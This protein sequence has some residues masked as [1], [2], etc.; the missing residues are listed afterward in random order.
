[1]E[2]DGQSMDLAWR[3][4][5]A[6]LLTQP[7]E[8]IRHYLRL[9][10]SGALERFHFWA[11]LFL[12][13]GARGGRGELVTRVMTRRAWMKAGRTLLPR[14][15]TLTVYSVFNASG[16]RSDGTGKKYAERRYAEYDIQDTEGPEIPSLVA[17]PPVAVNPDLVVMLT[18]RFDSW[19][20]Q[21]AE[22]IEL[23]TTL[24][25]G[26]SD[27]AFGATNGQWIYL[28]PGLPGFQVAH[29]YAHEVAH[30]ILGHVSRDPLASPLVDGLFRVSERHAIR[31]VEADVTA[32]IVCAH[33]GINV[34]AHTKHYLA[35]WQPETMNVDAIAARVIDAVRTILEF[36]CPPTEV[37]SPLATTNVRSLVGALSEAMSGPAAGDSN[38]PSAVVSRAAAII[39][40]KASVKRRRI[41]AW[42][43]EEA[44]R[45]FHGRFWV[46][47]K[48]EVRVLTQAES[49]LAADE[50]ES[51]RPY[52]LSSVRK[53][54][55]LPAGQLVAEPLAGVVDAFLDDTVVR[56]RWCYRVSFTSID[57]IIRWRVF[58]L[59]SGEC[60]VQRR[61]TQKRRRGAESTLVA[62]VPGW[63][64]TV[65]LSAL[66]S[67]AAMDSF[68][69]IGSSVPIYAHARGPQHNAVETE[70]ADREIAD[71]EFDD[72]IGA[73]Q[74]SLRFQFGDTDWLTGCVHQG[75]HD[76]ITG[77]GTLVL[78]REVRFALAFATSSGS[79]VL[80]VV[81][82][83]TEPRPRGCVDVC[84]S[85]AVHAPARPSDVRRLLDQPVGFGVPMGRRRT[86]YSPGH[87]VEDADTVM[88]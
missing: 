17:P 85:A 53:G 67:I 51:F 70:F 59:T 78:H 18:E 10:H 63:A 11:N 66:R 82:H 62:R 31:E 19:R 1:M 32:L 12:L 27:S 5:I 35:T 77:Q 73:I 56:G 34:V 83:Q 88:E 87:P 25:R 29:V 86:R 16:K 48:G 81:L 8:C 21:Q 46:L 47:T 45:H 76:P 61:E 75:F 41:L 69:L 57:R 24:P 72:E 4:F 44:L 40:P 74:Q 52:P 9:R 22:P 68:L 79:G 26:V 49:G 23:R 65:P 37:E 71:G 3:D 43:L 42:Y 14:A 13:A 55:L 50:M 54:P 36:A 7:D 15:R 39:S 6:R 80:V 30:I 33:W 60:I 58:A 64:T 20:A 84:W 38:A 2:T 28:Q